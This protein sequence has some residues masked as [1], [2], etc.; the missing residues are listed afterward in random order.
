MSPAKAKKKTSSRRKRIVNHDKN[1]QRIA[2]SVELNATSTQT[3][4]RERSRSISQQTL[5]ADSGTRTTGQRDSNATQTQQ[6]QE[7]PSRFVHDTTKTMREISVAEAL[8]E[9]KDRKNCTSVNL[10]KLMFISLPRMYTH[11][12]NKDELYFRDIV[13]S[14]MNDDKKMYMISLH[15]S[16]VRAIW[17][18]F[19]PVDVHFLVE[20]MG[21][22]HCDKLNDSILGRVLLGRIVIQRNYYRTKTKSWLHFSPLFSPGTTTNKPRLPDNT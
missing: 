2:K 13:T 16:D 15:H 22:S 10:V 17:P 3:S 14:D 20:M 8:L 21:G 9:A 1:E 11:V 6:Q 7:R 4:D 19:T 12:P 18:S 5:D